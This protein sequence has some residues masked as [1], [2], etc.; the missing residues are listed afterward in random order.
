M[1]KI[2]LEILFLFAI[3]QALGFFSGL[4]LI[5]DIPF[6]PAFHELS[7]PASGN[8]LFDG[9]YMFGF[10]LIGAVI[11]LIFIRHIRNDFLFMLLETALIATT[12]SIVF[13]SLLRLF[14]PYLES[15]MIAG[16]LGLILAGLKQLDDRF[17]N[18]SAILASAG[19]GA[20][21]GSSIGLMPLV[22]LIAL[23]AVYDYIAVFKTKHMVEFADYMMK[24]NVSFTITSKKYIPELKRERRMDLG[25]GDIIVPVMLEV[26]LI[27]VSP[28]AS[29]F[30]FLGALVALGI[31]LYL[32]FNKKVVLPAIPPIA[33]GMG[34]FFLIGKLAGMY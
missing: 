25:T 17:K 1:N 9:V 20:L 30:V 27:P 24:R 12:S 23:L 29:L 28:V 21:F 6:N 31:F 26:A 13:Y 10:M 3:A 8:D 22:I 18:V 15:M 2:I 19:V 7:V 32:F 14:F 11:M 34:V 4:V 5:S 33:F 16:S